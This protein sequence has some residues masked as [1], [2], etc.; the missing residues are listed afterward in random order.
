VI[1]VEDRPA[2]LGELTRQLAEANVN[3]D[4]AYTT[5]TGGKIVIATD[6][7]EALAPCS[8]RPCV[9]L[10]RGLVL[11]WAGVLLA[12]SVGASASAAPP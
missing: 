5:F 4:L 6:D 2:A 12:V 8:G 7:V 9:M 1:D 3:V 10:H 11:R